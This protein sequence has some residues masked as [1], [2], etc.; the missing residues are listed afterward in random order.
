VRSLASPAVW[1]WALL[2]TVPPDAFATWRSWDIVDPGYVG[3]MLAW[4]P[5]DSLA[6]LA[7]L[8]WL[9][10]AAAP[11]LELRQPWMALLPA[12]NAEALLSLRVGIVSLLGV[13]PALALMA[14][15]GVETPLRRLAW[16][17]LGLLGLIPALVYFMRRSLFFAGLLHRP[18]TG[19]TALDWSRTRVEGKLKAFLHLVLPW[20]ALSLVLEGLIFLL[21]LADGPFQQS[22]GWLLATPSLLASLLPIAYFV[23]SDET[24]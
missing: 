16:L 13:T 9:L 19:A 6:R 17:G 1:A 21:G 4:W 23:A 14:V 24:P 18:L 5:I 8:A 22:A 7:I 2:A 15:Q 12:I 3:I 10:R 11:R 20:W